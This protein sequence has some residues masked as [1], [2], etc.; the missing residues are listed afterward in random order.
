[1]FLHHPENQEFLR[2][3]YHKPCAVRLRLELEMSYT[4]SCFLCVP[5]LVTLFWDSADPL[6]GEI[7]WSSK[8]TET[9][10]W[11]VIS[12]LWFSLTL[13]LLVSSMMWTNSSICCDIIYSIRPS[14]VWWTETRSQINVSYF[15]L[16]FLLNN[17]SNT[18]LINTSGFRSRWS[19]LGILRLLY[20]NYVCMCV[21]MYMCVDASRGQRYQFSL[22]L[23]YR[24]SWVA[25]CGHW[26]LNSGPLMSS[27]LS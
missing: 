10:P 19:S 25:C 7:Q 6:R 13:W 3:Q 22:E 26:K 11:K 17:N 21:G 8:V 1:M 23:S 18:K 27:V 2:Y 15:N 5:K 12:G 16:N 20:D 4:S 24:W 9:G 14:P